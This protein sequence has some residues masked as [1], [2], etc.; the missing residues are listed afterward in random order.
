M[1][2]AGATILLILGM[3][4]VHASSPVDRVV[5]K[6]SEGILQLIIGEQVVRQFPIYL[7]GNPLGHKQHQGDQRTPEGRYL[8]HERRPNSRF[9][10]ALRVSYPNETD[11]AAA[12]ADGKPP[13][14]DIMIHG[15]PPLEKRSLLMFDGRNWTDGCIAISNPHMREVW[16]LVDLDTPIEILP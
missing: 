2:R 9:Y 13:G 16:D 14:G 5:V 8:L 1:K 11:R 7:G 4:S 10:R 15:M 12:A 3:A 6:K